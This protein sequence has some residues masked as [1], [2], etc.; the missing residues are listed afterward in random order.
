MKWFLFTLFIYIKIREKPALMHF[1]LHKS[2][3]PN[4]YDTRFNGMATP[5]DQQ[6][7]TNMDMT[8]LPT[9]FIHLM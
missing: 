6:T 8:S 5:L 9:H 2:H 3:T 7:L 1:A 4:S